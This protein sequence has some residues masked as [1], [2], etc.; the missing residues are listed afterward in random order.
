MRST[1]RCSPPADRHRPGAGR[2]PGRGRRRGLDRHRA[3]GLPGGD[4]QPERQGPHRRRRRDR[5]RLHPR[6]RHR[7]ADPLAAGVRRPGPAQRVQPVLGGTG[8][9]AGDRRARPVPVRR[10][11]GPPGLR[12][13]G[14]LRRAGRGAGYRGTPGRRG[15]GRDRGRRR[16]TAG[17]LGLTR[18]R[19]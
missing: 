19:P 14:S 13:D 7:A 18:G 11:P 9:G 17:P 15:G 3:A 8:A 2:G 1:C 5:H 4:Q 12:P 16:G 6:V 10:G